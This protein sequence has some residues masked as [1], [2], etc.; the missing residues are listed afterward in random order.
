M[1][2]GPVQL[3][4]LNTLAAA[5]V[6]SHSVV[7][8]STAT[9]KQAR[10]QAWLTIAATAVA[11][12]LWLIEVLVVDCAA[13]SQDALLNLTHIHKGSQALQGGWRKGQAE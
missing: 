3:F 12:C 9:V 10:S 11:A 8:E 4:Y 1:L 2:P 13:Y 6:P 5:G 7:L